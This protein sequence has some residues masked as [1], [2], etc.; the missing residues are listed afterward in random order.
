MG[1]QG[2]DGRGRWAELAED[3]AAATFRPELL[4]GHGAL[5]ALDPG[6]YQAPVLVSAV[7][8]MGPRA[9]LLQRAGLHA[10]VG[11]ELVARVAHDVATLGA[12][13]LLFM[14]ALVA[15]GLDGEAGAALLEGL[16]QGCRQAGCALVGGQTSRRAELAGRYEVTGFCVGVVE[17]DARLGPSRVV[18]GDAVVGVQGSPSGGFERLAEGWVGLPT[19]IQAELL[20]PALVHVKALRALGELVELHALATVTSGLDG[21]LDRIMPPGLRTLLHP[22]EVPE[23]YLAL[24]SW[25]E[26]S[27]EALRGQFNLGIGLCVVLPRRAVDPA[28]QLLGALGLPSELLGMVV[29]E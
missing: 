4:L 19:H 27:E 15:P 29:A 9:A 26:W 5:F 28:I 3:A 22:R 6:R 20:K 11:L 10:Q 18:P 13:P 1:K 25:G 23:F 8:G 21:A 7:A 14:D 17:R 16:A 24:Q 2:E 12:E